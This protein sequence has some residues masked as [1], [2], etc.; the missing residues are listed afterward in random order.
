MYLH[1]YVYVWTNIYIVLRQLQIIP[2][3]VLS[4]FMAVQDSDVYT[5]IHTYIYIHIH[6]Y[7]YI[8]TDKCIYIYIY[9]SE[10]YW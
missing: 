3:K 2:A 5:H 9:V 6:I 1:V 8:C 10:N 7:I 4:H